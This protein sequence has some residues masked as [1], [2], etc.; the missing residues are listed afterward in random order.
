MG[1]RDSF[2]RLKKKVRSKLLGKQRKLDNT[3]GDTDG[4]GVEP[5][6]SL[7]PPVT[8][9]VAGGSHDQGEV[10]L[11]AEGSWVGSG[12]RPTQPDTPVPVPNEQEEGVA[13]VDGREVSQRC[14]HPY[15]DIE[16]VAGRGPGQGE[17]AC[18]GGDDRSDSRS[19]VPLTSCSE[20]PNGACM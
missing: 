9:A 3:G 11:N 5:A 2:S 12:D 8:Y 17:D 1:V 10:E 15:A 13:D 14:S 7:P 20:N 4:E 18:K 19:S 16:V 6:S